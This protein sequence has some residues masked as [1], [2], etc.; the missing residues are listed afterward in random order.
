MGEPVMSKP[1]YKYVENVPE[2]VVF[3]WSHETDMDAN[4]LR[5]VINGID[6][7]IHQPKH[8]PA[9]LTHPVFVNGP[10]SSLD[11]QC[12]ILRGDKTLN[13]FRVVPKDRNYQGRQRMA[14]FCYNDFEMVDA[15]TLHKEAAQKRGRPLALGV[16]EAE[17]VRR[18]F[19]HGEARFVKQIADEV[20]VDPKTAKAIIKGETFWYV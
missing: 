10:V 19:Y 11:L 12:A 6:A 18:L 20:H 16:K 1:Q 17:R 4:L 7:E 3:H 9:M 2:N 5:V 15:K 14:A 8:G 13:E